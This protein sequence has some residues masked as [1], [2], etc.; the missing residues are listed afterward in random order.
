MM[1][2]MQGSVEEFL[3]LIKGNNQFSVEEVQ[4]ACGEFVRELKKHP[5]SDLDT[6][7]SSL[8]FGKHAFGVAIIL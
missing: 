7:L 6:A 1:Q 3:A 8:D 4:R 2:R 5:P